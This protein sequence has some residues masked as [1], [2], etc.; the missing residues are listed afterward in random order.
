[1]LEGELEV[2]PARQRVR[3][4]PQ[5][6]RILRVSGRSPADFR[7]VRAFSDFVAI[8][9][10]RQLRLSS[11]GGPLAMRL[12]DLL[13]PVGYGQRGL[14]I[15]P[16]RSGKTIL[17]QQIAHAAAE[18]QPD[19][20]I[21]VCL[22][23]ERPEEVTDMRRNIPG[24]VLASSADRDAQSHVRLAQLVFAYAKRQA[25]IG[26]NVLILLDSMTRLVRAFDAVLRVPGKVLTGGLSERALEGPRQLLGT[27]RKLED[28]GSV[29]LLASILTDTGS[30]QDE[31]IA[32]EF[33][34]TGNLEL[35]LSREL[36]DHRIWP[37]IDAL[38]SGTRQDEHL[39]SPEAYTASIVL[40]KLL[41]GKPLM[42]GMKSLFTKIR[43]FESNDD[44]IDTLG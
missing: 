24:E 31:F 3:G 23:D 33:R 2:V 14:V 42:K 29:T 5:V 36:A 18:L 25:E 17:L 35:L 39:L 34:G 4:I 1:M 8:E 10:E 37:A 7:K 38:A 16:P 13:I 43:K 20:E 41:D 9:P 28:A 32:S 11:E 6:S 21:I 15:A 30:A 22:I 40:R 12:I 44:L 26:R 27:A 19:L